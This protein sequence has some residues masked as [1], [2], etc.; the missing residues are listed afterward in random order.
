MCYV[1]QRWK[2]SFSESVWRQKL[3]QIVWHRNMD[4]LVVLLS[5]ADVLI[6]TFI[7]L[8]DFEAIQSGSVQFFL[9]VVKVDPLFMPILM[10]VCVRVCICVRVVFVC[11]FVCV[12][13]FTLIVSLCL[14]L[15][16]VLVFTCACP[17]YRVLALIVSCLL[18]YLCLCLRL[19]CVGRG[20]L[21]RIYT[22]LLVF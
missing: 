6:I 4:L 17:C 5:L 9:S 3:L 1:L 22:E 14:A 13:V 19:F 21:N 15:A 8:Q 16:L 2:T 18:C 20:I 10:P 7:I 12:F 11:L